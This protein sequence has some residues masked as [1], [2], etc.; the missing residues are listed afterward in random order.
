MLRL[1]KSQPYWLPPDGDEVQDHKEYVWSATSQQTTEPYAYSLHPFL[2]RT[3]RSGIEASELQARQNSL[4]ASSV[5][6][7]PSGPYSLVIPAT[8]Q[9]QTP[10]IMSSIE[11]DLCNAFMGLKLRDAKSSNDNAAPPLPSLFHTPN[12]R[13]EISDYTRSIL[14]KRGILRRTI[15]D[16]APTF[17]PGVDLDMS[18][19]S[20]HAIFRQENWCPQNIDIRRWHLIRP[21]LVLASKF[22]SEDAG[23]MFGYFARLNTAARGGADS[24]RRYVYDASRDMT[25]D[26]LADAAG[27]LKEMASYTRFFCGESHPGG[28]SQGNKRS[29]A[30]GTCNLDKYQLP[31]APIALPKHFKTPKYCIWI[32]IDP[33]YL[34]ALTA[35]VGDSPR[36]RRILFELAINL[37]HELCHGFWV[38]RHSGSCQAQSLYPREPCYSPCP[39]NG[40]QTDEAGNLW[41][42]LTFGCRSFSTK[43]LRVPS[44]EGQDEIRVMLPEGLLLAGDFRA[45]G[46]KL[47]LPKKYINQWF[48]IDTWQQIGQDGMSAVP[49]REL[50][51]SCT[52]TLKKGWDNVWELTV[53]DELEKKQR[54]SPETQKPLTTSQCIEAVGKSLQKRRKVAVR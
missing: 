47:L 3:L 13:I 18:L 8:I 27:M 46:K 28:R 17:L 40:L 6:L 2:T 21:A 23:D 5:T 16:G 45:V 29:L 34:D 50:T 31:F 10:A 12:P 39:S 42:Y 41:E 38:F 30:V 25:N 35:A 15:D 26:D 24:N 7:P 53:R 54:A 11:A 22:L 37:V 32:D 1:L 51:I 14:V 36:C 48:R 43:S 4:L 44:K 20:V 19:S 9:R 33:L 49:V 52:F